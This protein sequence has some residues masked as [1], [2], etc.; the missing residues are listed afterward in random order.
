LLRSIILENENRRVPPGTKHV[1]QNGIF[2]LGDVYADFV[3]RLFL[4]LIFPGSLPVW[5]DEDERL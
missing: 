3:V 2:V 5:L 4:G 1:P